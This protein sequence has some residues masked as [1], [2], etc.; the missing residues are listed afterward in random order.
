MPR[1]QMRALNAKA[2][3]EAYRIGF[4]YMKP[5]SFLFLNSFFC[6]IE[7]KVLERRNINLR[8]YIETIHIQIFFNYTVPKSN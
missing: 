1:I 6:F 5:L 2:S 8:L 3:R 7:Y 4:Q